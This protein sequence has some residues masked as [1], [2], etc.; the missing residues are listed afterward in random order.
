MRLRKRWWHFFLSLFN[1][2]R[3]GSSNSNSSSRSISSDNDS[4]SF[5]SI[6]ARTFL[7]AFFA[8]SVR[9]W[10]SQTFNLWRNDIQWKIVCRLFYYCYLHDLCRLTI[11][12][13]CVRVC[14]C[15]T[16]VCICARIAMFS[17]DN[18]G[19]ET[20]IWRIKRI[21]P[22]TFFFQ[23]EIYLLSNALVIDV[24]EIEINTYFTKPTAIN[25]NG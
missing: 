7:H 1:K 11:L 22:T 23:I 2:R 19:C 20:K 21:S 18:S 10:K 5:N 4:I 16:C 12:Y 9:C 14:V 8:L 6:H 24:I 25:S 17:A 3:S 13:A 15:L